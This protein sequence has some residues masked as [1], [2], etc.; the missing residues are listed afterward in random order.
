MPVTISYDLAEINVNARSYI[1]SML[2]RFNW[3]RLG[4]SV[5]RYDGIPDAATQ[6]LREDWLND[7]VPALM[8]FR[9][10]I[11]R[12]NIHLKFFTVDASGASFI[13][14]SD[15]T[16]LYGEQPLNGD[17][18]NLGTP[19]NEQSSIKALREFVTAATNASPTPA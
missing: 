4:G 2:E 11:L 15:S 7:V 18:L 17:A 14:H 10:F 5:F 16:L 9:S 8:F 13:D 6:G 12:N 19:T 1:R 3:H